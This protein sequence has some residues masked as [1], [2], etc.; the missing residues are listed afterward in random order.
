[1]M[2]NMKLVQS[3][4]LEDIEE[5]QK[6][7]A[8]DQWKNIRAP[9]PWEDNHEFE[10]VMESVRARASKEMNGDQPRTEV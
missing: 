7:G 4:L 2:E 10:A 8:N 1:M 5:M 6:L 3:N 9:R